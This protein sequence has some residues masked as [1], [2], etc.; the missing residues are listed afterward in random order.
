MAR[1]RRELQDQ[2]DAALVELARADDTEA[3]AVLWQR[4]AAAGGAAARQFASIAD[5]DDV[6]SEAYLRILRA[7]QNGGGPT[8]SFRPYLYRTIR[9]VAL[10]WRDKT[11]SVS[12]ELMPELEDADS[13]PEVVT[14][15]RGIAVRAFRT[16]PSRWQAVLWYLEVEG[17]DPAEVAPLLQL[18]PNAVSALA[19]RARE[20]LKK[21]WLQAHVSEVPVPPGCRW[22]TDRVGQYTRGALTPRARARFD[23]HLET[24]ER[25]TLLV[26]EVD[27]L[28]GS[29]AGILLPTVLGGAA[30]AGLLAQFHSGQP[31]PPHSADAARV[32]GPQA[33]IIAG[34]AVLAVAAIT[35]GAMAANSIWQ[36]DAA[37]AIVDQQPKTP[38]AVDRTPIPPPTSTPTAPAPPPPTVVPEPPRVPLPPLKPDPPVTPPDLT[39]PSAPSLLGPADGTLTNDPRPEFSGT[40]EPG[41]RIDVLRADPVTGELLPV[42]STTVDQGG[43]WAVS[44]ADAL[45]EGQHA[46]RITQVDAAGNRSAADERSLQVDTVALVPQLD[47][48]PP[49][50]MLLLPDITGAGEPGALV[51][52]RDNLGVLLG[53]AS[54]GPDGSWSLPLPD[55]RRDG[56]TLSAAQTDPAGNQSPWSPA[57]PGLVFDRPS[58]PSPVTGS[59]VPSTAGSTVVQIALAGHEGMH[60]EVLVDGVSTGNVH[61]LESTPIVRVTAPL[62]DGPHTLAVRYVDGGAVGSLTEITFVIS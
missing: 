39:A 3:F 53:R 14:A 18:T 27:G 31:T 32:S 55:P 57:T 34:A 59:T 35:G 7:L 62:G 11:N 9:N 16:L 12:L 21:A 24:C 45:P 20:G 25:C 41:A 8:E 10:D 61:T 5:P 42:A 56:A 40:G 17:M 29:L 60:V 49:Q 33:A 44:P 13:D 28:R 4:H 38:P 58:I 54:A 6:V 52:V 43:G 47:A 1:N 2:G 30:G 23:R 22:T 50:P 51:E 37:P 15:E 48:L 36:P 46:I 26:E 19:V